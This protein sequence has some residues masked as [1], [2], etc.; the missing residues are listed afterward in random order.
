[1]LKCGSQ[2]KWTLTDI[3]AVPY[4]EVSNLSGNYSWFEIYSVSGDRAFFGY[5]L[6]YY[7]EKKSH[8]QGSSEI[9]YGHFFLTISDYNQFM[10]V[11]MN[12]R[13]IKDPKTRT[14]AQIYYQDSRYLNLLPEH[15]A[16]YL[17]I[18]QAGITGNYLD[19]Y[20]DSRKNYLY[21]ANR[22]EISLLRYEKL[23]IP[24]HVLKT[25]KAILYKV[26][27]Y[28][29]TAKDFMAGY[30]YPYEIVPIETIEEMLGNGESIYYVDFMTEGN[31]ARFMI[32]QAPGS[33]V[34]YNR[35]T[36]STL[37]NKE[38]KRLNAAVKMG[39]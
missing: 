17:D 23:Y 9:S 38:I 13:L 31:L 8:M 32:L 3:E 1:V 7:H 28:S 11:A 15:T 12:R 37:K 33:R 10:N 16:C 22:K 20:F 27:D 36:R 39:R 2:E 19:K 4:S 25:Q 34:I 30:N 18:L 29:V 26:T 24:D 5:R 35:I 6:V 21:P 14:L